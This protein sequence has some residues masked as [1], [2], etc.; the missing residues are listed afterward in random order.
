MPLSTTPGG[1]PTIPAGAKTVSIKNI[2]KAGATPKE[3]V[4]VLGDTSRQYASPPLVEA[5][6]NTATKTC[7]VSGNLKSNTTLAV[8]SA[9]TVTG[10]ICESYEKTYE[11]GKYATFSAEFSYYPPAT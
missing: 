1:G 2:E 10:W 6:T 4:T 7:S 5:G 11:V 9:A 8:T 3:D